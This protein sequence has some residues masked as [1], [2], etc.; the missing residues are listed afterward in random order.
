MMEIPQTHLVRQNHCDQG[1]NCLPTS[2]FTLT[3]YDLLYNFLWNGKGEKIK[4]KVTIN[5]FCYGGLK[6]IDRISFN[7]S[8]I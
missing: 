1:I 6:M 7:K 5:D 8:L 3:S 4:P 2:L